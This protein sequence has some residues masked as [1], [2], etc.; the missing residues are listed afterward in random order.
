MR[1]AWC[2]S[3]RPPYRP[4]ERKGCSKNVDSRCSCSVWDEAGPDHFVVSYEARGGPR[5][6]GHPGPMNV[7]LSVEDSV[8]EDV[9]RAVRTDW[10]CV[11]G[12]ERRG[13]SRGK[14]RQHEGTVDGQL[15]GPIFY[16]QTPRA[17]LT[18]VRTT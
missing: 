10:N 16:I 4:R 12:D 18:H 1:T 8:A 17:K 9:A 7:G 3:S 6:D 5:K 13:R 14:I 11:D 2:G 15:G